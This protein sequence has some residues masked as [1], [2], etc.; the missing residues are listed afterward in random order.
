MSAH[1]RSLRSLL[2][3]PANRPRFVE[4]A[5]AWGADAIIFDLEDSVPPAEKAQARAAAAAAV[6]RWAGQ[7]LYLRVNPVAAR[8]PFVEALG[9]EDIAA[10]VTPGLHGIVLPKAEAAQDVQAADRALTAAEQ[11]TGLP[12]GSL[13]IIPLIETAR[14]VWDCLEILQASP[15]VRRAGFGALDLLHDLG[16]RWA[17]TSDT[18][19]Y[20]R[21]RLVLASRVAGC[22]PPIDT[23]YPLLD[24]LHGLE[25]EARLAR[26]LGFSGK[27]C[28]HPRQVPVVNTVF[29]PAP[30]E[31]A[32][33][34]R[35]MAAFAEAEA[36]GE[37]SISVDGTLVDYPVVHMA[38]RVLEQARALG[39]LPPDA[40]AELPTC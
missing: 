16:M 40:A 18:L 11:R 12:V 1:E 4:K 13:E 37:G 26:R 27:M 23:V 9:L 17:G 30:D 35:V 39:L 14:G 15:R 31:I 28:V 34:Q 2:F 32:W 21:T 38:R 24:D 20:A 33:A 19:L 25:Q 8:M 29:S 7:T 36:R 22:A 3:T 6:Q 10:A 5:G